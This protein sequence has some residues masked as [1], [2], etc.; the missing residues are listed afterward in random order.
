M[1]EKKRKGLVEDYF[2]AMEMKLVELLGYIL[3]D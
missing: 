3:E 2:Q 1:R